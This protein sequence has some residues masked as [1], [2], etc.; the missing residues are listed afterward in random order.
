MIRYGIDN[1]INYVDT[2]YSYHGGQSEFLVGEA[3]SDGYR[4]K[5]MLATKILPGS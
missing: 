1:G 2:A 5:V 3:L 4:D